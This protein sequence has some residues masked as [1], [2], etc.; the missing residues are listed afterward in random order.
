MTPEEKSLLERALAISEE[1]NK[2][3]R[4]LRNSHRTAV[5]LRIFYWIVILVV[6]YGSFLAIQPIF[7]SLLNMVGQSQG[8]PA[9]SKQVVD[10]IRAYLPK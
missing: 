8:S 5:F 9:Q 10:Q 7:N 2:I 6:S 3:L 1:N 4:G